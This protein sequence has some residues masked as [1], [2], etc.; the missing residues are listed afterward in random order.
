VVLRM[1]P[2]VWRQRFVYF[3]EWA[4]KAKLATM[5]AENGIL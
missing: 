4:S 5:E 1:K 2:I 3:V